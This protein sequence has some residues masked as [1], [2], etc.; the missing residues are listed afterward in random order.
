VTNIENFIAEFMNFWCGGSIE[1]YSEM[2]DSSIINS[3]WE[4]MRASAVLLA[5]ILSR[6]PLFLS[7]L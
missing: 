7:Y 4:E 2:R 5:S 3:Q 1:K 6:L